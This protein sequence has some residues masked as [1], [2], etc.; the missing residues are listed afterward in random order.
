[1]NKITFRS[2][3]SKFRTFGS[4][5]KQMA[6]DKTPAP[7]VAAA[8]KDKQ[9]NSAVKK[10]VYKNVS[11]IF[12]DLKK[13]LV[14]QFNIDDVSVYILGTK[15]SRVTI[16]LK[17]G[18]DISK[19]ELEKYYGYDCPV[20]ITNADGFVENVLHRSRLIEIHGKYTV[21]ISSSSFEAFK[22]DIEEIRKTIKT[23]FKEVKEVEQNEYRSC[24]RKEI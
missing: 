24:C 7:S 15:N 1:M 18:N 20:V 6:G 9:K 17:F 22:F 3:K 8:K 21:I 12:V 5:E 16:Q 23:A 19:Y 13:Q 11:D 14:N 4:S 10:K 2:S